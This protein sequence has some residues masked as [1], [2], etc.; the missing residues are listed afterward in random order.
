MMLSDDERAQR[1]VLEV[2]MTYSYAQ[3]PQAL[4]P[5]LERAIANAFAAIREEC[6]KVAENTLPHL[7]CPCRMIV[8][9]AI[10]TAQPAKAQ[11]FGVK[12]ESQT[13]EGRA[14]GA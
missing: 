3:I 7:S 1:L 6:A 2:D 13:T 11:D 4:R 8:A 9:D 14:E 5:I 10:R 12:R